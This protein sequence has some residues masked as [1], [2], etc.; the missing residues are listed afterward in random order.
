MIPIHLDKISKTYQE[1][2]TAVPTVS[3]DFTVEQGEF[4]TLL[5]PSGCGKSTLL[6]MIAG[7]VA[8]SSGRIRFADRDV[9]T[10]PAHKRGIGMVF[11]N[12]ALFPHLT[13]LDNVGYGLKLR[14]ITKAAR[15]PRIEKALQRVGLE[16]YGQRRID[17]LSGGQQQRVA[18]ARAIVI[19]PEVLLLDEPL[20][21]L[22][23]KLREETRMQIRDVQQAAATT[24]IYVTHDQAEAMAM[25]DRIAVLADGRAHQI[26]TP[27]KVYAEP[28]TAFVARFI[29]RSNVVPAEIAGLAE[30]TAEVRLGDGLVQ[31]RRHPDVEAAEGQRVELSIRP[32]SLQVTSLETARLRGL[33]R[34]REF[35]G[36]T[37]VLEVELEGVAE[38]VTVATPNLE[39]AQGAR[40]GLE[41]EPRS[42]WVI[43]E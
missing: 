6:R 29:G 27:Q 14:K 32:E 34:S 16:G 11:Q 23:A 20:S 33:V 38:T 42:G 24:A 7:F 15:L 43:P 41:V 10:T 13:V 1:S 17:Q 8:P 26:D 5:G 22:D 30:G 36:S 21:N 19:E 31:A 3:V 40:I 9:T 39:V 12:Y 28:A 25:S 35:L 18:L 4:F 2:A 37:A